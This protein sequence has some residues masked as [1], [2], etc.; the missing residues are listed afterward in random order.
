MAFRNFKNLIDKYTAIAEEKSEMSVSVNLYSDYFEYDNESEESEA[1]AERRYNRYVKKKFK[2]GGVKTATE[3]DNHRPHP[4]FDPDCQ[5]KLVKS[6]LR[7][8]SFFTPKQSA[9]EAFCKRLSSSKFYSR[10]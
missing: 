10:I 4:N 2:T 7:L 3:W 6:K 9:F 1:R 8:F 5:R